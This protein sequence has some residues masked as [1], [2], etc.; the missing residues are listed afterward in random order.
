VDFILRTIV[1]G[2][3]AMILEPGR[4]DDWFMFGGQ[5]RDHRL[6]ANGNWVALVFLA[7]NDVGG[8]C[9]LEVVL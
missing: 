2:T 3:D 7:P 6:D 8:S 9:V 4:Q 1:S 5:Y